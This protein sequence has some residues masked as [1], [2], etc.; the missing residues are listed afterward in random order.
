MK[1]NTLS[2]LKKQGSGFKTP[3]GYFETVET[4]VLSE[5]KLEKLPSKEGFKTPKNYF[6]TL[7]AAVLQELKTTKQTKETRFDVPTNYF[8]SV[9]DRVFEKLENVQSTSTNIISIKSILL[10]KVLPLAIAASLLLLV[11]LNYN[12]T[13]NYTIDNVAD[14]EVTNWIEEGYITL[15]TDQIAEVFNDVALTD[16]L[17]FED[18]E[19]IDYL[20][21]TDIE[22]ILNNQLQ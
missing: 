18:E 10:K 14:V 12:T 19:L 6:D 1:N 22:S 16:N 7:E 8:D 2:I 17:N 21:G 20:N 3:E 4:A 15:D 9:E 11:V 5:L 13:P